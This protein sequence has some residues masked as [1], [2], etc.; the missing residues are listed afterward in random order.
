MW[1]FSLLLRGFLRCFSKAMWPSLCPDLTPVSP[2]RA[3]ASKLAQ[4][5]WTGHGAV[6]RGAAESSHADGR[7]QLQP[8]RP[9]WESPEPHTGH[10]WGLRLLQTPVLCGLV[11]LEHRNSGEIFSSDPTNRNKTDIVSIFFSARPIRGVISSVCFMSWK[12]CFFWKVCFCIPE[13][14]VYP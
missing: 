8:H 9:E 2:H 1:K 14:I 13:N 12:A 3:E 5:G 4:F 11:L 10:H 6:R 7:L